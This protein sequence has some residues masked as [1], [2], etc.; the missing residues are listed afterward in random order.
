MSQA[1]P[2]GVVTEPIGLADAF[3]AQGFHAVEQHPVS[4]DAVSPA[5]L[6]AT[7]GDRHAVQFRIVRPCPMDASVRTTKSAVIV[8]ADGTFLEALLRFPRVYNG[9]ISLDR[10]RAAL[11]RAETQVPGEIE[12]TKRI[13]GHPPHEIDA[14]LLLEPHDGATISGTALP[15][16][17][18]RCVET[19]ART[20]T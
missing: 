19:V 13:G 18:A 3:T 8:S 14:H 2:T 7:N 6:T 1:A 16:V 12:A 17:C 5:G 10:Y 9:A 4:A 15:R 11:D 20:V